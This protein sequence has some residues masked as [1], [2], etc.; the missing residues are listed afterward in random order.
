MT[1]QV[2]IGRNLPA[3]Q[4]DRLQPGFHLLHGL[5]TSESAER[6]NVGSLAEQPPQPLGSVLGK[7]VLFENQGTW[8]EDWATW[9]GER[10]GER[11]P[12]PRIGSDLHRPQ[13]DAP[14]EYVLGR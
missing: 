1:R 6:S 14:G 10:A 4:V 3:R 11:R 9:I 7:R 5:L 13:R 12:P 2:G 8:W